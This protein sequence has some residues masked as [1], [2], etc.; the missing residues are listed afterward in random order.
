MSFTGENAIT[1]VNNGPTAHVDGLEAN[2]IW[3]ATDNLRISAAAAFYDTELQD[4]YCNFTAGVCTEVLA[5]A[6]TE[7]PIT[8]E[9]KGNLVAR[10]SFNVGQFDAHLQGALA[11]NGDRLADLDLTVFDKI[12]RLPAWTTLDL[13]AGIRNDSWGLDLFVSNA[14]GEDALLNVPWKPAAISS[15]ASVTGR[16]PFL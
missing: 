14:T 2:L 16:P 3:L 11:H 8:A 9:F 1:A 7:L 13:S 10:Y 6:G 4:D 15:M 5:P 12:G